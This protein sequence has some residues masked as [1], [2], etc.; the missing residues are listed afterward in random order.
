MMPLTVPGL[1]KGLDGLFG[2]RFIASE[3]LGVD[4]SSDQYAYVFPKSAL[5]LAI[6][7][8]L[9]VDV[10]KRYD[11]A[12]NPTEITANLGVGAVRMFEEKVV[13]I[14]CDPA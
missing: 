9:G 10:H 12:S 1:D 7:K 4:G 2:M 14:L 3:R 13:R 5:K 8:D 11:K 6:Y